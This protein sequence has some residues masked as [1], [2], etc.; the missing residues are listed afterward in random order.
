[1]NENTSD[2]AAADFDSPLPPSADTSLDTIS[3]LGAGLL[4]APSPASA[5]DSDAMSVN[6]GG[7]VCWEYAPRSGACVG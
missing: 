5:L 6:Q 1:V 4:A 2:V 7:S 3:I